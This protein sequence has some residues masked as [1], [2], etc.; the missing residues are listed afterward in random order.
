LH[1]DVDRALV[2]LTVSPHTCASSWV[3]LEDL[4]GYIDDQYCLLVSVASMRHD[5]RDAELYSSLRFVTFGKIM[6]ATLV[7]A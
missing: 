4:P 7:D 2:D 5:I 6:F 1:V 3:R